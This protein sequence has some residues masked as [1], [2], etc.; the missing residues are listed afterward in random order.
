MKEIDDMKIDYS[1]K[2]YSQNKTYKI[3][4]YST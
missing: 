4:I 2:T 3:S 1:L